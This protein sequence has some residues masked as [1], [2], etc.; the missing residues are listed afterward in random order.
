MAKYAGHG[1]TLGIDTTGAGTTH[2]TVAQIRDISGPS[3]KRD[4]IETTARDSTD[5]WREYVK[6]MKSG[7][8]ISLDVVFDPDLATH[9]DST[10]ILGDFYS[11]STV[12]SWLITFP[13]TTPT[14]F[15]FKGIVTGFDL[16]SPM[17]KEISAKIKI[18]VSGKITVA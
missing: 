11:D 5:M 15:K 7:G 12:Y 3:F 8:D 16:A 17:E 6:G 9:D 2:T 4:A 1:T 10:G 14:T 13:D 18:Q